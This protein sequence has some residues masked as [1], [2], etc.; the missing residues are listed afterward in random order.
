MF[1]EAHTP[2]RSRGLCPRYVVDSWVR[3]GLKEPCFL[4]F[5]LQLSCKWESSHALSHLSHIKWACVPWAA[6]NLSLK[7]K[8]PVCHSGQTNLSCGRDV[9]SAFRVIPQFK[10]FALEMY[11]DR[12]LRRILPWETSRKKKGT[13]KKKKNSFISITWVVKMNKRQPPKNWRRDVFNEQCKA[14]AHTH[15]SRG[16]KNS[17][18]GN[19][20]HAA[21]QGFLHK[22]LICMD[23]L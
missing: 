15:T 20:A 8:P 10:T 13:P 3:K 16:L 2:A 17:C 5:T 22:L 6:A 23:Q 21:L 12:R 11:F 4:L 9:C 14:R 7:N 1:Q 18:I 19:P